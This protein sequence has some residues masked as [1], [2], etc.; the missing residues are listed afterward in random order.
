MALAQRGR[1]ARRARSAATCRGRSWSAARTG[2]RRRSRAAR[3]ARGRDR[4]PHA[5]SSRRVCRER[6]GRR[7]D[8]TPTRSA[9]RRVE[10][11]E[12]RRVDGERDARADRRRRARLELRREQRLRSRQHKRC[13]CGIFKRLRGNRRASTGKSTCTSD[14]RSSTTRTS[15]SKVGRPLRSTPSAK[16]SGRIPRTTARSAPGG[17]R[18]AGNS[19]TGRRRSLLLDRRL[20]QI[21]PGEPM[22]RQRRD[23]AARD[24][25]A[26]ER[27]PEAACRRA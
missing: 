21:H 12:A 22:R 4:V 19:G 27:R 7:G 17:G 23:S 9:G 26:G 18:A 11:V 3:S 20:D 24:R 1:P 5:A 13:I 2:S 10:E 16:H 25:A 15:T 8:G 14:P 6:I